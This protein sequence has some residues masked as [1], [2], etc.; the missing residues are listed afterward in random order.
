MFRAKARTSLWRRI[1]TKTTP[2]GLVEDLRRRA[3]L[4]KTPINHS[5]GMLVQDTRE[6]S[7]AG[8]TSI[9]HFP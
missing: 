7:E 1:I 2:S 8:K 9:L 4:I 3:L 6:V 5:A